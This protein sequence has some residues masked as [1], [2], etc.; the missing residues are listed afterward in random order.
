MFW[1]MALPAMGTFINTPS[2][3][4]PKELKKPNSNVDAFFTEFIL[5]LFY[6]V[7]VKILSKI[8]Q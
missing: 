3:T 5:P 4:Q 8:S 7:D 1:V 6:S 2:E